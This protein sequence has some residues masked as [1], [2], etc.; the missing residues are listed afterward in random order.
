MITKPW[1]RLANSIEKV[2][3][4]VFSEKNLGSVS[5]SLANFEEATAHFKDLGGE[6][7]PKVRW[8]R[9][10][11]WQNSRFATSAPQENITPIF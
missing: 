10:T 7:K 8:D 2:N 4:G 5:K 11:E 6:L 1:F 9:L 3:N